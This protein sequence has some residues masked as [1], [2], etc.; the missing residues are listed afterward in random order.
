VT[1]KHFRDLPQLKEVQ[2]PVVSV[3]MITFNHREFIGEALESAVT[4]ITDFDYEIVVG[5][6]ASSDGTQDI[7]L[8]FQHRYPD[9]I[10]ALLHPVNLG[11]LGKKN[12][13]KTLFTCRGEYIAL[14]EG[15]DYW[16]TPHKLQMQVDFLRNHPECA[17]CY[18]PVAH[19]DS[20]GN[21]VGQV[22]DS[23]DGKRISTL[24]DL[25]EEDFMGTCS[26]MFRA[27]MITKMPEWYFVPLG[28]DWTLFVIL[29]Q[30]GN[31]GRVPGIMGA[32][33]C[34]PQGLGFGMKP[35]E[36]HLGA[37]EFYTIINAHLNFRF[38]R[39]I[40]GCISARLLWLAL[41]YASERKWGQAFKALG[42]SILL[43]PFNKR[44]P[45]K[46]GLLHAF[47]RVLEKARLFLSETR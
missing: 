45:W 32:H 29:S 30:H 22:G 17:M 42:Q 31:I 40:K 13:V 44:F 43:S 23:P 37:I 25:I 8:D 39:Q 27:G 47:R 24:E 46:T 35:K 1:T 11:C 33:R 6:D 3:L 38:D 15:D 34:H 36:L 12:L 5:D 10:R 7:I 4:Q 21:P 14:L 20:Q 41:I 2:K 26:V 18:H 9:K 19:V 16:T 28:G